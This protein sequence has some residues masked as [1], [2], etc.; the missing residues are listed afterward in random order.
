MRSGSRIPTRATKIEALLLAGYAAF[1]VLALTGARAWV[2][3]RSRP[4]YYET[5]PLMLVSACGFLFVISMV[6]GIKA[7]MS[8]RGSIREHVVAYQ[9]R[10]WGVAFAVTAVTLAGGLLIV[11]GARS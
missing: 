9:A 3:R 6:V 8:H 11:D 2:V 4:P 5:K 7:I 10:W 1:V